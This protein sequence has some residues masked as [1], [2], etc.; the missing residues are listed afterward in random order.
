MSDYEVQTMQIK[1]D[2][3]LQEV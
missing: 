2:R 1:I 3:R